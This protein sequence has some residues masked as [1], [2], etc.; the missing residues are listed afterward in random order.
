MSSEELEEKIADQ[1]GIELLPLDLND[2]DEPAKKSDA[3]SYHSDGSLSSLSIDDIDAGGRASGAKG[4]RKPRVPLI[5][6][7]IVI[8]FSCI[9]MHV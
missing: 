1:S 3:G 2:D 7:S 4:K 9:H 6:V 8:K 5:Q